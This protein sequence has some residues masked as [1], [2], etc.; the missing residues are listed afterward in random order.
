[1]TL[2]LDQ[3]ISVNGNPVDSIEVDLDNLT[4]SP[5]YQGQSLGLS[6][7]LKPQASTL[8]YIIICRDSSGQETVTARVSAA[9]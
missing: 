2:V 1:M 4:V 7:P 8:E 3:Q 5:T 6:V 9:Y